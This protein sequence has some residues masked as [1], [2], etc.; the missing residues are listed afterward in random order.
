MLDKMYYIYI[1]AKAR[2]STFYTGVTS[3]LIRQVWEHKEGVAD[4]FTKPIST[5]LRNLYILKPR[6]L[7]LPVRNSSRDGAEI[8]KWKP[9]KASILNG[10]TCITSYSVIW[11][12]LSNRKRNRVTPSHDGVWLVTRC[13]DKHSM[14]STHRVRP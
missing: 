2:N 5:P 10:A 8:L 12:C 7:L 14:T 1:L 11:K 6:I 13:R 9:S 4:G 3:D